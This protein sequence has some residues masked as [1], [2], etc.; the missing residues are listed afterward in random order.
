MK[1]VFIHEEQR[2]V[3]IDWQRLFNFSFSSSAICRGLY[4]T[5]RFKVASKTL[6]VNY[7]SWERLSVQRSLLIWEYSPWAG[8]PVL[9]QFWEHTSPSSEF[10]N[11]M[12]KCITTP[13]TLYGDALIPDQ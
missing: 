2:V 7:S 13:I 3:I 6:R 11:S 9:A 4:W 5:S 10:T 8:F 1:G 12:A